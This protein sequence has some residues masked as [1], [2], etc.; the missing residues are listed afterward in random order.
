VELL[1][2]YLLVT[3]SCEHLTRHSVSS[4]APGYQ[5]L[6]YTASTS[7]YSIQISNATYDYAWWSPL[8]HPLTTKHPFVILS[9]VVMSD[10]LQEETY[11][12]IPGIRP[13]SLPTSLTA[14]PEGGVTIRVNTEGRLRE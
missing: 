10:I 14:S 8:V 12:I 9:S 7:Q 3:E 5:S 11:K 4:D 6:T 13:K 2:N 1:T